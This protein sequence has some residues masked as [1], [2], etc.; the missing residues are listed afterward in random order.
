MLKTS[1]YEYSCILINLPKK[2][3]N[4]VLDYSKNNIDDSELF[5]EEDK[6]R[7]DD[8][9]VTLLYGI[10]DDNPNETLDILKNKF[11]NSKIKIRLGNIAKFYQDDHDVLKINVNDFTGKLE[12]MFK[13]FD[14]ELDNDNKFKD[15]HPHITLAYVKKGKC[16]DLVGDD[17][18]EDIE[19]ELTDFEF[20]PSEDKKDIN[21]KLSK[22]AIEQPIRPSTKYPELTA[23]EL[24]I[25]YPNLDVFKL[26]KEWDEELTPE[27]K[28]MYWNSFERFVQLYSQVEVNHPVLYGLKKKAEAN[29]LEPRVFDK[30][31]QRKVFQDLINSGS[32]DEEE[33]RNILNEKYFMQPASQ[34]AI[35]QEFLKLLDSGKINEFITEPEQPQQK[36][37][38]ESPI[39]IPVPV[40]QPEIKQVEQ[41]KIEKVEPEIE[42]KW[43]T[44]PIPA[45]KLNIGDVVN[46]Q[47][48]LFAVIRKRTDKIIFQNLVSGKTYPEIISNKKFDVLSI[49]DVKKAVAEQAKEGMFDKLPSVIR[50]DFSYLRSRIA[51]IRA[52]WLKRQTVYFTWSEI[53]GLKDQL[54][55]LLN[56]KIIGNVGEIDNIYDY[57]TLITWLQTHSKLD[58]QT[59]SMLK[60][61]KEDSEKI[62]ALQKLIS[63]KL[64]TEDL[65]VH[66]KEP[67]YYIHFLT[68]RTPSTEEVDERIV[69]D[70]IK[71][72]FQGINEENIN[73]YS[74]VMY[75]NRNFDEISVSIRSIPVG[76]WPEENIEKIEQLKKIINKKEIFELS[77]KNATEIKTAVKEINN[78][79]YH[80]YNFDIN[81]NKL[82]F[83][84]KDEMLEVKQL[85]ENK[86]FIPIEKIAILDDETIYCIQDEGGKSLF[87]S[88]DPAEA[89]WLLQHSPNR[90]QSADTVV[91][92][93]GEDR[94]AVEDMTPENFIKKWLKYRKTSIR[95][96]KPRDLV[97]LVNQNEAEKYWGD[98]VDT[99]V[100]DRIV[101]RP[102]DLSQGAKTKNQLAKD[103]WNVQWE[104]GD[105]AVILDSPE[106][107]ESF[108][109]LLKTL[110]VE[111]IYPFDF[112]KSRPKLTKLHPYYVL[113]VKDEN[114]GQEILIDDDDNEENWFSSS[115][116]LLKP[117]TEAIKIKSIKT[118][119]NLKP[120]IKVA[121]Y[122]EPLTFKGFQ[123]NGMLKEF[124]SK[125]VT[126]GLEYWK[127]SLL[128]KDQIKKVSNK[129]IKEEISLKAS[130]IKHC[131]DY[132]QCY[133][134]EKTKEVAWV[135]GDADGEPEYDSMDDIKMA[136]KIPGIKEVVIEDS[137]YDPYRDNSEWEKIDYKPLK[138]E[139]TEDEGNWWE[140]LEKKSGVD[141]KKEMEDRFHL[142][143]SYIDNQ[144]NKLNDP[145]WLKDDKDGS[146]R[147]RIENNIKEMM[148][149]YNQL[150]E[151]L[152]LNTPE[153]EE[154][155]PEKD[156]MVDKKTEA[157]LYNPM[158]HN[159]DILKIDRALA[160]SLPQEDDAPLFEGEDNEHPGFGIE[161]IKKTS[162]ID[163][164]QSIGSVTQQVLGELNRSFPTALTYENI[165]KTVEGSGLID[166]IED[167]DLINVMNNVA[168]QVGLP[169]ISWDTYLH[170]DNDEVDSIITQLNNSSTPTLTVNEEQPDING[171]VEEHFDNSA[172]EK[173]DLLDR[174]LEEKVK[175]FIN[176]PQILD[177]S[178]DVLT[179]AIKSV[180]KD[181]IVTKYKL[182]DVQVYNVSMA[183]K[184]V[185]GK[186][187]FSINLRA[188]VHSKT[189]PKTR[190]IELSLPIKQEKVEAPLTFTY[191]GKKQLLK[192]YFLNDIFEQYQESI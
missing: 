144:D 165:F 147:K 64:V 122:D 156:F 109:E 175:H 69:L 1:S 17:F 13:T 53:Q 88:K 55:Q 58:K 40:K 170:P 57:P 78:L 120:G 162:I 167:G 160:S 35:L 128:D 60:M 4:L 184:I 157:K 84:N 45:N 123:G 37:Q 7:E 99:T 152:G 163:P 73:Y 145:N 82:I 21:I 70:I 137:E 52:K 43:E 131:G 2:Y 51:A 124:M 14:K 3:S 85:L 81:G 96:F 186:L 39:N 71:Q 49:E 56:G 171:F 129:D 115:G 93:K 106:K 36:L 31:F 19:V 118:M 76:Q 94:D 192:T 34:D 98:K 149:E 105:I 127:V 46:I 5:N 189:L 119:A 92:R 66:Y 174:V 77:L 138:E 8:I 190:I 191:N 180:K 100:P 110:P 143:I 125:D 10:K 75:G 158:T 91:T 38:T 155:L 74:E 32:T 168:I 26:Y 116:F 179:T 41:P 89:A 67:N 101:I 133:Y 11:S 83:S 182:N 6:G 136:L 18:F 63:E 24:Q 59:L 121:I 102:K 87:E 111:V 79:I 62:V 80:L 164:G 139:K 140:N 185:T 107:L 117:G 95:Q 12:Q 169:R 47:E 154:F 15:Y 42:E 177:E 166:K 104:E 33:L 108:K 134:N 44:L 30:N 141:N 176:L 90:Y 178:V 126:S 16:E 113:E 172:P 114:N 142:L 151:D 97:V 50:E 153:D 61:S 161:S 187:I 25:V 146:R 181:S 20:S 86:G 72:V 148:I 48:E 68:P 173:L 159:Y 135:P 29:I 183:G 27:D 54:K 22:L 112:G 103:G 188:N 65:T 132:G 28:Q 9:H 130:H 23:D 150:R